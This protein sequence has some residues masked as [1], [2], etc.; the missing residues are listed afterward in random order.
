MSKSQS[1]TTSRDFDSSESES[2]FVLSEDEQAVTYEQAK[3]YKIRFGKYSGKR[4]CQLVRKSKTRDYLRYLLSWKQLRS[5]AKANIACV[6]D[7]YE[8]F[9]QRKTT[10]DS[11]QE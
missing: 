11:K 3:R 2:D 6:L 5:E 8:Q 4:L 7:E 10:E 1:K 9:K